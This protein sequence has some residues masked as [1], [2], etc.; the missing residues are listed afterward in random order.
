MAT[1]YVPIR[2]SNGELLTDLREAKSFPLDT[3]Y[4]L[5][6]QTWLWEKLEGQ[7]F[8]C[9]ILFNWVQESARAFKDYSS[10]IWTSSGRS[11]SKIVSNDTHKVWLS[12]I[13]DFPDVS[14]CTCVGCTTIL[15]ENL[16]PNTEVK[17]FSCI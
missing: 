2:N 13:F 6:V 7:N 3:G 11:Y 15:E 8:E 4:E 5:N 16:D 10:R 9:Q 12:K 14:A 17:F 1:S